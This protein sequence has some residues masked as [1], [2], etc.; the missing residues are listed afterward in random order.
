MLHDWI[1]ALTAASAAAALAKQLTADA[2][3]KKVTEL[4]CGVILTAV[5]LSPLLKVDLPTLALSMSEYRRT[6]AELTQ[7]AEA[8]ENRLLRDYIEQQC[9]A[10]I[11]REAHT[12]GVEDLQVTVKTKW[13]DE[14]W[15]P[16]EAYCRGALSPSA[17]E[18]LSVYMESE[19]GIPGQNQNWDG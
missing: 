5:L 8:A 3:V 6:A 1:C 12:L 17:K 11:L 10:Y 7:D 4:L 16:Y 15:V 18:R 19:L 9:A 2:N 14:N 13:R